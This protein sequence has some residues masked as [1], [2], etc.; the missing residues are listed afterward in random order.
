M[1]AS[2][3]GPRIG[4]GAIWMRLRVSRLMS[5]TPFRSLIFGVATA[6]TFQ[7]TGVTRLALSSS[8]RD[9]TEGET[10]AAPTARPASP[11]IAPTI[12]EHTRF[13]AHPAT[14]THVHYSPDGQR[15]VTSSQDGTARVWTPSG[16][17]LA[18]LK[19]HERPLFNANFSPDGQHIITA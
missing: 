7:C 2:F 9:N 14:V 19:G 11:A 18:E 15:L 8:G 1:A 13:R 16:R 5:P 17:L 3:G 6:V 10:Q 12:V 4:F